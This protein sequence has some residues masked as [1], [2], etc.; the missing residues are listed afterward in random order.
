MVGHSIGAALA[1]PFAAE[2][3]ARS[4][5]VPKAIMAVEPG[6]C[7]GCGPQ[8]DRFALPLGDLSTIPATTAVLIVVGADDQLVGT[9]GAEVIWPQLTSVPLD[10]RDLVLLRSDDHGRPPL[11]ADHYLPLAGVGGWGADALDWYGTWKLFDALAGCALDGIACDLAL[12]NTDIQRDMGAW[13][14][15]TPVAPALVTDDP[16]ELAVQSS[17][18]TRRRLRRRGG[19]SPG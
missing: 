8:P 11:I 15:S 3:V 6:G 9:T 2:A 10:R 4:L 14:D 13:S 17:D 1:L 7:V 18:V 5:P 12:G 19:G 16:S